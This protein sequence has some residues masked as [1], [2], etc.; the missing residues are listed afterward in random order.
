MMRRQ[1]VGIV[2]VLAWILSV[3]A[4]SACTSPQSSQESQ[5][6]LGRTAAIASS[7]PNAPFAADRAQKRE[8]VRQKIEAVLT[9]EQLQQLKTKLKQGEKMRVALK[10]LNLQADQKMKIRDI[11]RAAY[12]RHNK[13]VQ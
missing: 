5:A 2:C 1:Q 6:D 11:L 4:L 10:E 9:P 8:E 3:G 13:Q 12:P 7:D